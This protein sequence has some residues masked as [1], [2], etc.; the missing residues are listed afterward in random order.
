MLMNRYF[1]D[2]VGALL[3]EFPLPWTD[4]QIMKYLKVTS[5]ANT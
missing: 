1:A 2:P 4:P 3:P 5:R